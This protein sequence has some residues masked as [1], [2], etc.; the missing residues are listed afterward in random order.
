MKKSLIIGAVVTGTVKTLKNS[1]LLLY[2]ELLERWHLTM[3]FKRNIMQYCSNQS[4][5]HCSVYACPKAQL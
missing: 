3:R 2:S 1:T 5:N 4:Q